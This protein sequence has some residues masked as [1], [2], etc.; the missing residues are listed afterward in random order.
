MDVMTA[1][2][3]AANPPGEEDCLVRLVEYLGAER[4]RQAKQLRR[5]VKRLPKLRRHLKQD[6]KRLEKILKRAER[7]PAASKVIS[8]TIA[9]AIQLSSDL[10]RPAR[11][12]RKNLHRYRLKVKELR[13][14][15][16][17]SHRRREP[18]FVKTLGE[19]K[20]AIGEWHDWEELTAIAEQTLD[21]GKSC[22]MAEYLRST[23]NAKYRRALLT[24]TKLRRNYLKPAGHQDR[25]H[26]TQ[27]EFLSV[28]VLDATA[29]V[30]SAG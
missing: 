24:A 6:S 10:N 13:N 21:H 28:P 8:A 5:T 23:G 20:D 26:K 14:V 9:K 16:Q 2:A 30:A 22:R 11:L 18:E 4:D 25:S 27:S 7:N 3:L 17:L 12:S 15:L 29:G 19:V 1:E